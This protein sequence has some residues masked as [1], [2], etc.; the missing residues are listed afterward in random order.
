MPSTLTEVC[1][2]CNSFDISFS[3]KAKDYTVSGEEFEI[4][5]CK[6]CSAKFTKN[7]PS[8][9]EI[10][11]Y[12]NSE[13]YISH[14]D[15]NSGFINKVYHF[16]RRLTLRS[17]RK[18]IESYTTLRNGNILDIGSGTGAFAA[19]MKRAGWAV[20]ALEPDTNAAKNSAK[21]HNIHPLPT[22]E[23]FNISVK[24]EAITMWHVLEHVY[25]VHNYLNEVKRLLAQNG[26]VFIAVPNFLCYDETVY[27]EF[28][29]AYD[30]PRHLYH[31]SPRSMESLLAAHGLKVIEMKP[32]W[33]DSFY[34]SMLSEKYKTGGN[35]IK[36]CFTGAASN[37]KALNDSGKCS[38]VIYI[39]AHIN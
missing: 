6:N 1:P 36:A 34:V 3:L 13:K 11:R 12:Y 30:V 4:W 5:K 17:K 14:S 24:F 29:A 18:L 9:N 8:E 10:G 21:L 16:V 15:S 38:S 28:W 19:E 23:L 32:M 22:S 27:N 35:I 26:R 37:L 25:A 2:L 20:T 33:F 31:F 7:P 39:A